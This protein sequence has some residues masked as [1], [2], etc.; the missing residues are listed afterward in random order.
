[1]DPKHSKSDERCIYFAENKF[2]GTFGQYVYLFS[3]E[4]LFKHFRCSEHYTGGFQMRVSTP[5]ADHTYTSD[6][7]G[8]EI[9]V[10]D[11]IDVEQYA[12]GVLETYNTLQGILERRVGDLLEH[13]TRIDLGE[14]Y[15]P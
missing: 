2:I 10:Y 1:M 9:R 7:L 15:K 8:S 6:P 3:K 12:I 4:V 13:Q 5:L 14:I 11:P